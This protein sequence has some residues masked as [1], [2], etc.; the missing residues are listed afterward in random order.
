METL[1]WI[2]LRKKRWALSTLRFSYYLTGILAVLLFVSPFYVW[3]IYLWPHGAHLF[4]G[5]A[6]LYV[7][8]FA[9]IYGV[10]LV[11]V[12]AVLIVIHGLGEKYLF[13][14]EE[15]KQE[16]YSGSGKQA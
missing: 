13:N 7:A 6:T 14:E 12:T 10:T 4:S 16:G 15:Q 1:E 2:S 11:I 9:F 8:I 3:F 5:Y